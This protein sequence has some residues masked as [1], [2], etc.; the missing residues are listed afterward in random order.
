MISH[1]G[2]TGPGLV[3]GKKALPE[4]RKVLRLNDAYYLV[5]IQERRSSWKAQELKKESKKKRVRIKFHHAR[6]RVSPRLAKGT[7][8]TASVGP[9]LWAK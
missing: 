6:G 5:I 4:L 2:Q 7:C 9:Y 1:F 3:G 8:D